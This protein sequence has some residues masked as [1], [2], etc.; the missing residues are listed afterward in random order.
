MLFLWQKLGIFEL[1]IDEI[2]HVPPPLRRHVPTVP[3]LPAQGG[4]AIE[5]P[6]PSAYRYTLPSQYRSISTSGSKVP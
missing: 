5:P 6:L 1:I 2:I 4:G 3:H